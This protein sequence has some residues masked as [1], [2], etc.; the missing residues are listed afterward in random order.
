MYPL[1][2]FYTS[3]SLDEFAEK[4]ECITQ[5][6]DNIYVLKSFVGTPLKTYS[7]LESDRQTKVGV[8][9]SGTIIVDT[10]DKYDAKSIVN[11]ILLAFALLIG[12]TCFLCNYDDLD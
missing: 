5:T 1:V 7:I 12:H 8:T 11:S 2:F 4:K 9:S 10:D 6:H 3:K